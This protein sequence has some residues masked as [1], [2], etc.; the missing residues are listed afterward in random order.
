MTNPI[1]GVKAMMQ[2]QWMSHLKLSI[3]SA[4]LVLF[5]SCTHGVAYAADDEDNS[6]WNLDR[7]IFDNFLQSLGLKNAYEKEIEYRERSPLVVPPS[8]NL[9]KPESA[10]ARNPAWPSDPD[11]KRRADTAKRKRE[12]AYSSFDPDRDAAPL[13][14]SELRK[15]RTATNGS[16][17][18]EEKELRNPSDLGYKGGL[19]NFFSP[20]KNDDVG[21]FTQEPPRTSLI[22]PPSGYQTPSPAQPYGLSKPRPE[23]MQPADRATGDLN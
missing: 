19:W 16:A 18:T 8:R 2:R 6:M 1:G 11:V 7:R 10:A 4:A 5:A 15:G 9:P 3:L 17:G 20:G 23:K 22:A 21:T 13:S 14:P 12:E